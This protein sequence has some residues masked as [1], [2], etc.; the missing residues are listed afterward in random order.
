MYFTGSS[1][2]EEHLTIAIQTVLY[3]Y[4]KQLQNLSN[5]NQETAQ[6]EL[7][8]TMAEEITWQAITMKRLTDDAMKEIE[9]GCKN[10]VNPN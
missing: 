2:E 4:R 8:K 10:I 6:D 1:M 9:E 5:D 3:R 7:L